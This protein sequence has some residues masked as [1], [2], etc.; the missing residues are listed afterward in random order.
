MRGEKYLLF[1]SEI[2]KGRGNLEHLAVG[3]K[4]LLKWILKI[5]L[6]IAWTG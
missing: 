2:Q 3:G 4:M 1:L 6:G 5:Q